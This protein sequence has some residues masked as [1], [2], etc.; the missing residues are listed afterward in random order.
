MSERDYKSKKL[1]VRGLQYHL[2]EW[3]DSSKPLL[4][5]LHGWMDCGASFKYLVPYLTDQFY[6]VAPDL[7]GFGESEHVDN[8]YWVPDYI[9]DLDVIVDHYSPDKKATLIGH[10]MGANIVLMYAGLLYEKV[11][12]VIALDSLGLPESKSS[13]TP[14]KQR[15][16]LKEVLS[17]EPVKV[18]ESKEQ[19]IASIKA[20]NPDLSD[21]LV[22]DLC[23]L[24]AKPAAKEGTFQLKHDHKHRYTNPYRY[25]FDDVKEVWS[26]ITAQVSIVMAEQSWVYE[27]AEKSGRIDTAR[28]ILEVDDSAYFLIE[29]SGH[30]LHLQ[31]PRLTASAIK[32]FLVEEN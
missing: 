27:S 14:I 1:I 30:M 16:W 4:I 24:W 29:D 21:A 26:E 8:G 7:R 12:K 32:D 15:L 20:M 23:D 5:I 19:L 6:I 28:E 10:S 18:Y 31:Q 3:G 25:L 22:N 9:A 2:H 17:N 11:D 13:D